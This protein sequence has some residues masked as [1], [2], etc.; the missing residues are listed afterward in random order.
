MRIAFNTLIKPFSWLFFSV[1]TLFILGCSN[2]NPVIKSLGLQS[3]TI[4]IY[5]SQQPVSSLQ[6]SSAGE[7][8]FEVDCTAA[9]TSIEYGLSSSGPWTEINKIDCSAGRATVSLVLNE[10]IQ[11]KIYLRT[12]GSW[13]SSGIKEVPVEF[14]MNVI[15]TGVP[16]SPNNQNSFKIEISGDSLVAYKYSFGPS[17]SLDCANSDVYS[18]ERMITT[19][20]SDADV[21]YSSFANGSYR[22]CVIVKTL[23]GVWTKSTSAE[24]REWTKD[25]IAQPATLTKINSSVV[26]FPY[27]DSLTGN[28]VSPTLT[29]NVSGDEGATVQLHS[30][31]NCSALLGSG[32]VSDKIATISNISAS[33]TNSLMQGSNSFWVR[34]I[35]SLSNV[36]SCT[37]VVN[38]QLDSVAPAILSIVGPANAIY[39]LGDILD[40]DLNISE[41]VGWTKSS[42][43]PN[44]KLTVNTLIRQA[45]YVD[46]LSSSTKLHFRYTVQ[47][48]DDDNDGIVVESPLSIPTSILIMD[49][50]NN[51]LSATFAAKVFTG[52]KIDTAGPS[53]TSVSVPTNGWYKSGSNIDFVLNFSESV[54]I[55][56]TPKLE[57]GKC[58][59][60]DCSSVDTGFLT[61]LLSSGSGS[62]NLHFLYSIPAGVSAPY[63]VKILQMTTMG[64]TLKDAQSNL[65][66]LSIPQASVLQSGLKFDGNAPTISSVS[67]NS[68]AAYATGTTL[69]LFFTGSVDGA[70]ESGVAKVL[71]NEAGCNYTG[72]WTEYDP[73][74]SISHVTSASG[75]GTVSIYVKVKDNAGNVTFNTGCVQDTITLDVNNPTITSVS[76]ESGAL[77]TKNSTLSLVVAASDVGAGLGYYLKESGSCGAAPVTT[78]WISNSS[79]TITTTFDVGSSDGSKTV[80]VWVKDNSGRQV[81]SSRTIYRDIAAPTLSV[82]STTPPDNAMATTS[83]V[84]VTSWG[85]ADATTDYYYCWAELNDGA[86]APVGCGAWVGPLIIATAPATYILA[87]QGNRDLY[88]VIKDLAGNISTKLININLDSVAPT[89]SNFTLFNPTQQKSNIVRPTFTVSG[90]FTVGDTIS[91]YKGD[92]CSSVGNLYGS[93]IA[94]NTTSVNVTLSSDLSPGIHYFSVRVS[95]AA[96]NA[97]CQYYAT[98]AKSYE[99][100][101]EAPS[102]LSVVVSANSP[103]SKAGDTISFTVNLAENCVFSGVSNIQL[104]I[105]VG[106]V[107]KNVSCATPA[108]LGSTIAC[109]YIVGSS[110]VDTDGVRFATGSLVATGTI[111]D[112]AGNILAMS[113]PTPSATTFKIDAI[114]PDTSALSLTDGD[115][116][117]DLAA[118]PSIDW[119]A[120]TDSGSGVNSYRLELFD[121]SN[122]VISTNDYS[123]APSTP[124]KI[125]GLT[126]ADK[127]SSTTQ[128]QL[129]KTKVTV[130]DIAGNETSVLSDGWKVVQFTQ[131]NSMDYGNST[132]GFGKAMA[133][134]EDGLRMIV[135]LESARKMRVYNFSAGSEVWTQLAEISDP[136]AASNSSFG[137]SVSIKYLASNS[138]LYAV[139]APGNASTQSGAVFVFKEISSSINASPVSVFMSPAFPTSND[140]QFGH[141][142]K[143]FSDFLA[144]G[145]PGADTNKVNG[146][147][148]FVFQWTGSSF[149]N[150]E[151]IAEGGAS[152]DNVGRFIAGTVVSGSP[153]VPTVFSNLA[154]KNIVRCAYSSESSTW[155][156]QQQSPNVWSGS[157]AMV[158]LEAY[159]SYVVASEGSKIVYSTNGGATFS[160][161]LNTVVSSLAIVADPNP[162]STANIGTFVVSVDTTMAS[163]KV[164]L[165]KLS[166]STLYYKQALL[167]GVDLGAGAGIMGRGRQLFIGNPANG[168]I[169]P[170]N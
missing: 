160:G 93:A 78:N 92:Y 48:G 20:I 6:A 157:A 146:G 43:S 122:T 45:S 169:Q 72:A 42:G 90:S 129:Y 57:V 4:A 168:K 52:V 109:S 107:N 81:C 120:A 19:L 140:D 41:G 163:R 96:G 28:R 75:S 2:G 88:L 38:Y 63:G 9:M 49:N 158:G 128:F 30:N 114:A 121:D 55:T 1:L 40:F 167:G 68:G 136:S 46:A 84:S 101:V 133:I 58:L 18:D 29:F 100:D 37:F 31:S 53:I 138:Y 161:S 105:V 33:G 13:G 116:S 77:Y 5:Q 148:L 123:N 71:V 79:N 150:G 22:V 16:L 8:K 141:S 44:L 15:L 62:N 106:A 137:H 103:W 24:I 64:A 113:L 104:P 26:G 82:F 89:I 117:T 67:T 12:V 144:V 80:S 50:F 132:D 108:G 3:G 60:M 119:N 66:N 11:N 166:G 36:S 65:A 170:F 27:P 99:V 25:T 94:A 112:E 143:F 118:T 115:L 155:G 74:E 54:L 39:T 165:R 164:E 35:D 142:L 152:S 159:G 149:L 127:T 32:I 17:A 135:G 153:D 73:A 21:K 156:A 95:D 111:K 56:G 91:I 98:A 97:S 147:A 10:S 145:S 14:R 154:N 47:A 124:F 162:V 76:L 85:L 7:L 86:T 69:T 59:N 110:D 87:T 139:G 102:V 23:K 126:L 34:T 130:R 70:N 151:K 83:S 125:T 61:L 51:A 134:S 131:Q